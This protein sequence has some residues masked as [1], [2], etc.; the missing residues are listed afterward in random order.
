MRAGLGF[1]WGSF[2]LGKWPICRM[3]L[4]GFQVDVGS[5]LAWLGLIRARCAAGLAVAFGLLQ[6][7]GS[8]SFGLGLVV[9]GNAR[10]AGDAGDAAAQLV[11]QPTNQ[12]TNQPV[13]EVKPRTQNHVRS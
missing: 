5:V 9:W 3:R 8:A 7:C 1:V 4:G 12:P 13:S 6:G 10:N 2:S 11:N